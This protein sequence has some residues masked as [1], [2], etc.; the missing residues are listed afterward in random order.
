MRLTQHVASPTNCKALG[1]ARQKAKKRKKHDL[2]IQPGAGSL[3]MK[4]GEQKKRILCTWYEVKPRTMSNL[5][6]VIPGKIAGK[7]K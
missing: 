4:N 5:A 1:R 6:K 2:A 7:D 3:K